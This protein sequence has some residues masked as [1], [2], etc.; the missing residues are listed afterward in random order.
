[1]Y[2]VVFDVRETG[3]AN[4]PFAS[5]GLIVVAVGVAMIVWRRRHPYDGR[6]LRQ[7]AHPY[8][9]LGFG[10]FW[11]TVAF[12]GTYAQYRSLRDALESGNCETIEG[13][14]TD[15]DPMPA[16]DFKKKTESFTVAGHRFEY[17][18]ALITAGFNHTSSH[19]GPIREGLRV[20]IA[21]VGGV[22]ARLEVE[23]PE[24]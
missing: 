14:V 13:E 19:G 16:F 21:A 6:S 11:T 3:Y 22:I 2:E 10:L 5:A 12:A 24:R 8:L 18:D 1:V 4:W 20:R 15:F 23:R 17:S 9:A 7:R